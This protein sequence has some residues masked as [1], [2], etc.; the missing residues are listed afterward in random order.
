[1]RLGAACQTLGLMDILLGGRLVRRTN[2]Y[3]RSLD[4]LAGKMARD[5]EVAVMRRA[6]QLA[7]DEPQFHLGLAWLLWDAVHE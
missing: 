4:I 5:I 1:M 6:A 3:I 7:S 2:P